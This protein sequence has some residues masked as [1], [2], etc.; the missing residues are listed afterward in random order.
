[1]PSAPHT[2]SSPPFERPSPLGVQPVVTAPTAPRRAHA[3]S[4]GA[5]P[6][7]V[8][9]GL[10][11]LFALDMAQVFAAYRPF[12]P[13]E[14]QTLILQVI[15]RIAVPLVAYV[16]I[17]WSEPGAA[18]RFEMR[19]RKLLSMASLGF[20]LVCAS[21]AVMAVHSGLRLS[22]QAGAAVERE[23]RERTA[24]LER[25]AGDLPLMSPEHVQITYRE[26]VRRGAGVPQK[27]LSPEEMRQK[28]IIAVPQALE[29]SRAAAAQA[30]AQARRL[31]FLVSA[32]YCIGGL[33]SAVLF[34]FVWEATASARRFAIFSRRGD[35]TLT[36][37]ERVERW[38]D[39]VKF[40]PN[41]E[42]YSWYRRLRRSGRY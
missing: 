36:A 41:F 16:L 17:F 35:S 21:L 37:Q 9:Y 8:G 19:V 3:H 29:T 20:V 5:L 1:M 30:A 32:K 26:L 22:A 31:Q 38:M 14:D 6:S 39:R 27:N 24:G 42:E 23:E 7:V 10:L 34:L 12:R 13:E 15:E 2:R 40:L 4:C 25:L 11:V 18:N 28:I 33:I